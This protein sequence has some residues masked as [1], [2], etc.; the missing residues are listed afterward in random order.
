[1]AFIGLCCAAFIAL[2]S[3]QIKRLAWKTDLLTAVTQ[4]QNAPTQPLLDE[5]ITAGEQLSTQAPLTRV[6]VAGRLV[7]D[8]PV[9]LRG[10][11]LD[12][13][14]AYAVLTRL[15]F[16]DKICAPVFLGLTAQENLSSTSSQSYRGIS[17]VKDAPQNIFTPKNNAQRNIWFRA[18][19]QDLKNHWQDQSMS[20]TL[21]YLETPPKN[22]SLTP[23]PV[24][25][26]IRNNHLQYA[27]FWFTA[28]VLTLVIGV[29]RLRQKS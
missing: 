17:W 8:H 19:A 26:N 14:P 27:L 15:C 11:I 9:F 24:V 10:Q 20:T 1:M 16:A 28:A 2:G 29:L 12:G 3:W 23:M 18:D 22:L 21:L 7:L 4:A 25:N 5:P 13:K 6:G